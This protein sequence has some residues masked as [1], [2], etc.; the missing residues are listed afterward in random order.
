MK[1]FAVVDTETT[2]IDTVMS[3]GVV[4]AV[5]VD[6]HPVETAYFVLAP[7]F[8]VGGMYENALFHVRAGKPVICSRR[9]AMQQIVALCQKHGVDCIFAYNAL[10]DKGHLPELCRMNWFDIMRLA[11]YVQYNR[12]IPHGAP[13]YRT[14]RLKSGYGVENMLRLLSDDYGYHETHNALIDA[15]DELDLMRL[16]GHSVDMYKKL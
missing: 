1:K 15:L 4:I 10:F 16:L 2:W 9:E 7:E 13:L 12:K 5:A 11:A 3:V 14:G 6:M 8:S